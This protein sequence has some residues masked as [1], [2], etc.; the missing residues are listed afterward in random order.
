MIIQEIVIATENYIKSSATFADVH[1]LTFKTK[2]I[3]SQKKNPSVLSLFES[4]VF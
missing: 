3:M 2:R 4:T 1:S